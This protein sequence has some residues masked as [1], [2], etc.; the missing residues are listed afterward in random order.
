[1]IKKV[2][3][4]DL[5]PGVFIADFNTT[6]MKHPFMTNQ[7]LIKNQKMIQRIREYGIDEVFIDTRRGKDIVQHLTLDDWNKAFGDETHN[8]TVLEPIETR[9]ETLAKELPKARKIKSEVRSLIEKVYYNIEEGKAVD[10]HEADHVVEEM[11]HSLTRNKDALLSLIAIKYKDEYTYTHSVNV[12]VLTTLLGKYNGLSD[13]EIHN[14]SVGAL[15]H[16]IGK[17][18]ISE[19]IINKPGPLTQK[20]WQ[21]MQQH[22]KLGYDLVKD[23][24]GINEVILRVILEHHERYDGMGYPNGTKGKDISWGGRA[25]SVADI[26]DAITSARSYSPAT[27]PSVALKKLFEMG[28]QNILDQELVQKFINAVGIYPLGSLV[29]LNSGFLGVVVESPREHPVRPVVKLIYDIKK[30]IIIPPRRLD[31]S[32]GIG[33]LHSIVRAESYAEWN[34][35][36]E[37]YIPV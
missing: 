18:K 15:L 37:D 13:E 25:A 9:K 32:Q 28:K 34:L 27:C 16:D 5:K 6:W 26:Y 21:T 36:P 33:E 23:M 29:K 8:V 30:K 4:D 7:I 31:L 1:M 24:E 22:P 19:K 2:K 3:V 10:I 14:L 12:A 35:R 20:E 11:T 17:T